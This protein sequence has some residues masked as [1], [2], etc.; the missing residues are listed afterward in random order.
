MK[1]GDIFKTV[2]DKWTPGQKFDAYIGLEDVE[3][4]TGLLKSTQNESPK[5]TKTRFEFGDIIFGRLRPNLNKAW[6]ANIENA[7]CSTDFVVLRAKGVI[8][9]TSSFYLLL[10]QSSKLNRQIVQGI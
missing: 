6:L 1:L 3:S 2:S 9:V 7:I 8:K 4:S 10:L 5:S